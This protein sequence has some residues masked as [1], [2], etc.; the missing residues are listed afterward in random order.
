MKPARICNPELE[1]NSGACMKK[2]ILISAFRSNRAAYKE[3]DT[4]FYFLLASV[5]TKVTTSAMS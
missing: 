1:D 5:L 3:S 2:R 4:K